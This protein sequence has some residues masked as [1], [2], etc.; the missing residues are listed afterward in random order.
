MGSLPAGWLYLP[1]DGVD[2]WVGAYHDSVSGTFLAF[3]VCHRSY[4]GCNAAAPAA[5]V[6]DGSFG[7][8]HYW[9]IG[10]QRGDSQA[11]CPSLLIEMAMPG[12]RWR[13]S[14]RNCSPEQERRLRE[15]LLSSAAEV[16]AYAN[17]ERP[18]MGGLTASQATAL[19]LGTPWTQVVARFGRPFRVRPDPAGGFSA[20][21]FVPPPSG[22]PGTGRLRALRLVVDQSHR[23]FAVGSPYEPW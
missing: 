18:P 9:V 20:H 22:E 5:Y 4:T 21:F 14:G 11:E 12:V 16:R 10:S 7:Q 8:R 23:I 19:A 13:F 17:E 1:M 2:S 3:D 15:L 6:E